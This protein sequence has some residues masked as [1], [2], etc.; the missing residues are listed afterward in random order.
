[1]AEAPEL[2][3]SEFA[4]ILTDLHDVCK[5]L[6]LLQETVDE[7]R[8][9]HATTQDAVG[10]IEAEM[11]ALAPAARRAAAMLDTPVTSYLSAKRAAA[12]DPGPR[13]RRRGRGK[14]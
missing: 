13:A 1:M 4:H 10:R 7:L 11:N 14:G 3:A 2:A 8:R 9:A 5:R 6:A 12:P